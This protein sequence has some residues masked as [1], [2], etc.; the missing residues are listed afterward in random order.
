MYCGHSLEPPRR[1]GSNKYSLEPPHR[2]GSNKYPQYDVLSR[3]MKKISEFL[4]E[5][6]QFLVMKISIYLNGRVFVTLKLQ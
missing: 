6:F 1:G 3:N 5:S 2:G 4:S